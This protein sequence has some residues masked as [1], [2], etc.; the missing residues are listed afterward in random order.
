[1]RHFGFP[2]IG[3]DPDHASAPRPEQS[4][5]PAPISHRPCAARRGLQ[6]SGP[7]V[8]SGHKPS[9]AEAAAWRRLWKLPQAEA[10]HEL[11]CGDVVETYVLLSVSAAAEIAAGQARAA[12]LAV[13][14]GMAADLG[15][16]PQSLA[17][18]RWK[19]EPT[20]D[21]PTPLPERRQRPRAVDPLPRIGG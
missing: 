5:A 14:R 15:L 11:A 18:L 10:W 17:R 6:P 16:T 2:G 3:K 21:S 7:E 12:T 19:I 13:L 8:A 1:M 9:K 20:E 4:T